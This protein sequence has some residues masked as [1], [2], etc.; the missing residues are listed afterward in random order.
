MIGS[1]HTLQSNISGAGQ[2]RGGDNAYE[3]VNM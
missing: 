3:S 1:P 2:K